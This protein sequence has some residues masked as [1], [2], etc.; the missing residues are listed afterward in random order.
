MAAKQLPGE[1]GVNMTLR[2]KLMAKQKFTALKCEKVPFMGED[3]WAREV[4]D[5]KVRQIQGSVVKNAGTAKQSIDGT[6]IPYHYIIAG[7][8]DGPDADAKP[9]FMMGDEL[10]LG[11]YPSSEIETLSNAIMRLSGQLP[12]SV[13]EAVK[14]SEPTTTSGSDASPPAI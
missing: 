3:V 9:V 14:N 10:Y 6:N 5:K 2:E 8:F 4:R 7:T 1:R 12:N 11:D 13:E